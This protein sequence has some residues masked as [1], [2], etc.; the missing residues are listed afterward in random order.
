ILDRTTTGR[1]AQTAEMH[2]NQKPCDNTTIGNYRAAMSG[3]TGMLVESIV[4]YAHGEQSFIRVFSGGSGIWPQVD[5]IRRRQG[6]AVWFP[7][8]MTVHGPTAL[9]AGELGTQVYRRTNGNWEHTGQIN[10][11]DAFTQIATVVRFGTDYVAQASYSYPLGHT[12][13]QVFRVLPDQNFEAVAILEMPEDYTEISVMDKSGPGVV[14]VSFDSVYYWTIPSSPG[15]RGPV[16]D[17]FE[18]GNGM[19]WT[20]IAGSNF[21]VVPRGATH[22][23][24]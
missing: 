14:A 17:D 4:D 23:F 1:W 3:G 22:V 24:R 5:E 16:Q 18:T 12:V 15:V 8:A 2:G 7:N 19:Q 9:M 20:T 10:Y 6:E 21:K 11:L 13:V